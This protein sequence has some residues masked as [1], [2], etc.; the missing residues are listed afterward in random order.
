M[1]KQFF[2]KLSTFGEH[3]QALTAFIITFAIIC[4]SWGIERILEEYVFPRKPLYGYLLA[5][6]G[7]LFLLWL[8]KHV[9]L[10]VI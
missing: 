1:F 3:H 7:G 5:I 4:I 2:A 6:S 10:H 9:I 8:T